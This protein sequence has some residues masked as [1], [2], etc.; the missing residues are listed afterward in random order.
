MS[1]D[2]KKRLIR[3]LLIFIAFW[4][5]M[6]FVLAKIYSVSPW[7]LMSFGMYT[8]PLR[9]PYVRIFNVVDGKPLLM[10]RKSLSP[11]IGV[12]I[13]KYE[14][15]YSG[16]GDLARP[17]EVR[18]A[19]FEAYPDMDVVLIDVSCSDINRKTAMVERNSIYISYTR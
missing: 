16:L 17:D 4:P 3:M 5:F 9:Y 13:R 10:D 7:K 6:H 12:A 1:F 19:I 15:F 2:L 14:V 18:D 11:A 8:T